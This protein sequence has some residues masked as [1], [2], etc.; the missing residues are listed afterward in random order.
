MDIRYCSA[1]FA[2]LTFFC[3]NLCF[4]GAALLHL[5][6]QT[7]AE[8]VWSGVVAAEGVGGVWGCGRALAGCCRSPL[9]QNLLLL[10]FLD[11]SVTSL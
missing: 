5:L 9:D 1:S 11:A 2:S 10:L 6:R 4:L 7:D 8:T 3:A